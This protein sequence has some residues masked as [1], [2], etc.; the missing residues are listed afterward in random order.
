VIGRPRGWL[1]VGRDRGMMRMAGTAV[2]PEAHFEAKEIG[3]F[4]HG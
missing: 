3:D 4:V 2:I 1:T